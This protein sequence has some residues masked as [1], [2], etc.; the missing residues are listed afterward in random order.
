MI[1]CYRFI[2]QERSWW[3]NLVLCIR[4][5]L[6]SMQNAFT[7][8]ITPEPVQERWVLFLPFGKWAKCSLT[9][10]KRFSQSYLFS[11]SLGVGTWNLIWG[12]LISSGDSSLTIMNKEHLSL[13]F[14]W[15]F[16]KFFSIIQNQRMRT[17]PTPLKA[18]SRLPI[19]RAKDYPQVVPQKNHHWY[20]IENFPT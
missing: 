10:V 19:Y 15:G 8:A 4:P 11:T 3:L 13:F 7:D 12:S 9:E 18:L 1:F 2:H 17:N 14:L 16:C 6:L 5:L 20:G